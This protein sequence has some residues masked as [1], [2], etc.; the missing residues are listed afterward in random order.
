M[1]SNKVGIHFLV[2]NLTDRDIHISRYFSLHNVSSVDVN[3]I[4]PIK[5]ISSDEE[6][7]K[8]VNFDKEKL[9]IFGITPCLQSIVET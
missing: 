2:T 6:F 4:D 5:E 1:N 8:I 7:L 9:S 3:N